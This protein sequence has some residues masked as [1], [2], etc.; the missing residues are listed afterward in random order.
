MKLTWIFAIIL[1]IQQAPAA[2]SLTMYHEDDAI[3]K[4][5]RSDFSHSLEGLPLIDSAKLDQLTKQVSDQVRKDP[6]DAIL[7]EH[8]RI[9]PER[10]GVDLNKEVF[11]E[12]FY[13]FF[14][15]NGPAAIDLP[16]RTLHPRVDSELLS[17]IKTKLIGHYVTFFNSANEERS[18]NITLAAEAINNKVIFPGETFSFNKTVGIRSKAKGYLPAPIIVRGE[19]SEG[20]GGG[21]CQVS[22]TLFNAADRSGMHI[23]KRYSH[24]KRVPYVPPGRDATVSWYGPDFTFKNNY[25]QPVLIRA[26]ARSGKMSVML[27]S[28]EAVNYKPRE[29]NHKAR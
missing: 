7:D 4:V 17:S 19:L 10:P 22:S 29:I 27:Y 15:G 24:S 9:I 13:S 23:M 21:I 5:N 28:S 11:R 8:G 1:F 26:K 25:N 20:I 3:I 2:E 14:Y 16:V 12:R 6:L 18:H